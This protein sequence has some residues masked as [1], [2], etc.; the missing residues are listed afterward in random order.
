MRTGY[1]PGNWQATLRAAIE[2]AERETSPS[3]GSI[4]AR[5]RAQRTSG[6]ERESI[7]LLAHVQIPMLALRTRY[8][9]ILN[10]LARLRHDRRQFDAEIATLLGRR[11]PQ[12]LGFPPEVR[13]E[14]LQLR[15]VAMG[16]A[17][18]RKL[19]TPW[20]LSLSQKM[21]WKN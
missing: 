1:T 11:R 20:I 19:I 2:A 13:A 14:L 5:L 17:G 8:P 3:E 4:P 16:W 18:V 10:R 12:R 15:I 21:I 7:E 9:R 6:L